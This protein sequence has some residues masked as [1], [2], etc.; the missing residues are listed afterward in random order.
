VARLTKKSKTHFP[1]LV[2]KAYSFKKDAAALRKIIRLLNLTHQLILITE[3]I[4]VKRN[5]MVSVAAATL[6]HGTKTVRVLALVTLIKRKKQKAAGADF[7]VWT[8]I[9]GD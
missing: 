9:A 7:V 1:N 6:P 8:S 5:Q 3:L 4:R 2:G